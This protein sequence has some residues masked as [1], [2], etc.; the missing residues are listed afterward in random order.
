[1]K[2]FFYA[3]GIFLFFSIEAS[4]K[5]TV[6]AC[7]SEWQAL[8]REIAKDK[9]DLTLGIAP[10]QNPQKVEIKYL[11]K[12]AGKARM[13]FC[14]GGGLEEKWLM[15][16][17]SDSRNIKIIADPK[18]NILFAYDVV[19]AG[20]TGVDLGPRVHLNPH[21]ISKIAAEFTL[22]IKELDPVNANFYQNSYEEFIKKWQKK[23]V[24]WEL[25]SK[26]L[27]GVIFI[28]QD[29]SWKYLE[30]WLQIKILTLADFEKKSQS[31]IINL[32]HF[33]QELDN[34]EV[35]A[36]IFA[37]FENKKDL[38]WLRD[39]LRKR[40]ILLPFTVNGSANSQD[41][42]KMFDATVNRLLTD[43]SSGVCKSL[44]P[45]TKMTVKFK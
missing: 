4:A 24:E 3:L 41:L 43:C 5:V 19:N 26:A 20:K 34:V 14:S 8:A 11:V 27:K 29:N 33:A 45:A 23:I 13:F 1:M 38:L 28:A 18:K 36:I 15:N 42:T 31:K 44:A 12:R 32:H 2:K 7:E 40:M 10:T 22:K 9:I 6:F 39:K 21:N 25:K 17:A 35:E 16:L 37:S 30:D